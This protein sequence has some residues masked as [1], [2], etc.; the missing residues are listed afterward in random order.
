M[1]QKGIV[2]VSRAGRDRGRLLVVVGA[3]DGR[4]LCADGKKRKLLSPKPKNISHISG[5]DAFI[6]LSSVKTD[7]DLRRQLAL[8]AHTQNER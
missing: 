8:V 7:R 1:L 4:V 3:K 5:I 6:D 2:V